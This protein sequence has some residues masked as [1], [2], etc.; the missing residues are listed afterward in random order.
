MLIRQRFSL[1]SWREQYYIALSVSIQDGHGIPSVN[2]VSDYFYFV[3]L[4]VNLLSN[5]HKTKHEFWTDDT[6]GHTRYPK[7]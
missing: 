7:K 5:I 1:Y 4:M 2:V 6:Y 3:E